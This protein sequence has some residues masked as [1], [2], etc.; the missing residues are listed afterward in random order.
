MRHNVYWN[1]VVI[2]IPSGSLE[3]HNRYGI[4]LNVMYSSSYPEGIILSELLTIKEITDTLEKIRE[5]K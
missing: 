4:P 2:S 1:I 5:K 3:Q